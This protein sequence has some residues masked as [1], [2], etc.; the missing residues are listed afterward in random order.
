MGFRAI[1]IV[2]TIFCSTNISA[3]T[4]RHDTPD[5]KYIEYGKKHGCIFK[6]GG[7]VDQEGTE[8]S[9]YG[10]CVLISKKWAITAAHV[11]KGAKRNFL[12]L[13]KKEV[14]F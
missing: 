7:I 9:Y 14:P 6:I 3:G 1:L 4:I 10:S 13:E 2:L 5:E 12:I 8:I 11:V